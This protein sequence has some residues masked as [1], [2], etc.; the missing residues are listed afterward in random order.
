MN[1]ILIEMA[2]S[3]LNRYE[4]NKIYW[5]LAVRHANFLAT[6]ALRK[7][8]R[9]RV[10]QEPIRALTAIPARNTPKPRLNRLVRAP[11]TIWEDAIISLWDPA[12]PKFLPIQNVLSST[13]IRCLTSQATAF[14]SLRKRHLYK[15]RLRIYSKTSKENHTL[16]S[17]FCL[18]SRIPPTSTS[19]QSSMFEF[20][21][22]LGR[23]ILHQ[24]PHCQQRHCQ[25]PTTTHHRSTHS[26]GIHPLIVFQ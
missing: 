11:I 16:L 20:V 8:L 19:F 18:P 21:K 24:N 2:H 13:N 22:L 12:K 15:L 5:P 25:L 1:R 26:C 9:R 7:D 17:N 3:L 14:C 4:M 6:G 10:P 23:N